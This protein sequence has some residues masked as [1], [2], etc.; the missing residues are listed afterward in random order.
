MS[1]DHAA[2][3]RSGTPSVG[4]LQ[5]AD[6]DDW[7]AFVS[8]H[9]DAT[10]YHT[11]AW[12]DV[13]VEVFRHRPLYLIARVSGAVTGVLPLFLVQAPVLGAKLI[14]LPYDIGLGGPLTLDPAVEDALGRSAIALARDLCTKY[15]ELRCQGARPVLQ[16]LGMR[17]SEPVLMSEMRLDGTDA[18]R[19][20]I[21]A[22][23]R[24][25][26]RKA[27]NRGV[28]VREATRLDDFHQFYRIYL[29]V[30][31]DFGTPPYGATYFPTLWRQLA[32]TRA[33]RLLLAVHEERIVGGLIL[34]CWQRGLVSK[35]A[36]CLPA[37]VPLRAYAALY[38]HAICLGLEEGYQRLS[39][40]S[41]SRDQTGLIEFK[42]R[43]GATTHAASV[44]SLAV[45]GS[46]PDLERYYDSGGWTR[47]V[48]RA[49]PV[50]ATRWLGG[51]INRWFC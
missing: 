38:W 4:L 35:F 21:S 9:G 12:R 25:A 18:V 39:W 40:G 45:N 27:D 48:W 15:V 8:Q 42:E 50:P 36:A 5:A 6:A 14:S 33:V 10:L 44:Y 17:H 24:K 32:P 28:T 41:S 34:F 46:V 13:V 22:D 23:H 3:L 51:P 43:W 29:E 49:L 37:A 31:R 1:A 7:T 30:F 16:E 20:R 2:P 26:I 19:A 11:L 47:R